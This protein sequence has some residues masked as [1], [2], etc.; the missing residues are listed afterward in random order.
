MITDKDL[1][2][3][4]RCVELA[5]EALA[6]G[7]DP[8]GSVLASADGEFLAEGRNRETTLGDPTAH[9]E[10]ELSRWAGLNLSVDERAGA[11]LYTSGE[12]C[13]MCS[14]A[15]GWCGVGRVVYVASSAQL[16]GWLDEMGA[17]PAPVRPIAIQDIAPGI[18]VEGPAPELEERIHELHRQNYAKRNR[19]R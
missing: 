13:P 11:T 4:R 14:A 5:G 2:Y 6:D 16:V 17:S 18:T 7:D 8:F 19:T 15:Q 9:P 1:N 3:L 12:H 10:F